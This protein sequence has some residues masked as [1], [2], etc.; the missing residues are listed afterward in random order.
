MLV[1]GGSGFQGSQSAGESDSTGP[2]SQTGNSPLR[3]SS[4]WRQRRRPGIPDMSE[5]FEEKGRVKP[6]FAHHHHHHP[7]NTETG[8]ASRLAHAPSRLVGD[9]T[10]SRTAH[11]CTYSAS[12]PNEKTRQCLTHTR[13]PTSDT[14]PLPYR[15][16][17]VTPG[18][19]Y[20]SLKTVTALH[21]RCWWQDGGKRVQVA[22]AGAAGHGSAFV[23]QRLVRPR[24]RITPSSASLTDD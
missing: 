3:R 21:E 23:P 13:R 7:D 16:S 9:Y 12:K 19:L 10:T 18:L 5:G 22:R 11:L 20:T 1:S 24:I 14:T 8:R 6:G 17:W 4:K 2:I 15:V